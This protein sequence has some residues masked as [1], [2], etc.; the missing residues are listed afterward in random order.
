[1]KTYKSVEELA[2]AN[3]KEVCDFK[4]IVG[5]ESWEEIEKFATEHKG[6]IHMIRQRNGEH[7]WEDRGWTY[8]AYRIAEHICGECNTIIYPNEYK[9]KEEW[10]NNCIEEYDEDEIEA[11]EQ[12]KADCEPVWEMIAK[13]NES[14]THAIVMYDKYYGEIE[15]LEGVNFYHDVYSYDMGVCF[16]EDFF[17]D[18]D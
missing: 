17:E 15:P 9:T 2:K 10:I 18:E 14:N 3:G 5:F 12:A 8:D 4:F 11:I 16:D 6:E 1:M 7:S 13:I